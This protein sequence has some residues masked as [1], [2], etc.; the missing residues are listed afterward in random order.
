MTLFDILTSDELSRL[1]FI[2]LTRNVKIKDLTLGELEELI[3]VMFPLGE[4]CT[5]SDVF[6]Q[7]KIRRAL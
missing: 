6:N 2:G 3:I 5:I 4:K 1:K 7:L